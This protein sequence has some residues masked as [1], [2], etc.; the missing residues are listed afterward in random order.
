MARAVFCTVQTTSKASSIVE[1]LKDAGFMPND[2]SVLAPNKDSTKEFA[3]DNE[4]KAP[5]GTAVGVSSGALLGG[6]PRWLAGI[7]VLAIP[8]VDR[9]LQPGQSWRVDRSRNRVAR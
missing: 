8:G 2:I 3:I 9:S 7:G 6:G 1:R 4:T 5:E